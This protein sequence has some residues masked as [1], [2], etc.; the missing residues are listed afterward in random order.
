MGAAA[1]VRM[2]PVKIADDVYMLQH[3][4]GVR[5]LHRGDYQ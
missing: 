3:S 5:K 2:T 4:R 1:P